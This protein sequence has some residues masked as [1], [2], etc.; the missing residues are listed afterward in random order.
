MVKSRVLAVLYFLF[1]FIGGVI[2]VNIIIDINLVLEAYSSLNPIHTYDYTRL[3]T[4]IGVYSIVIFVILL[5][6]S[7]S[8]YYLENKRNY[9]VI[10]NILYI[11]ATLYVYVTINK[12]FYE[13]QEIDYLQ[14]GEYWITVFMGIFYV[15]GAIL[16]S[17]IGYI[18]IRNY[19]NRTNTLQI[20]SNK[21]F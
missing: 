7:Y 18:T 13:V 14:Q 4:S 21:R 12:N 8:I 16:I 17:S 1:L 6:L 2:I 15:I 9:I 10:S 3:Q 11:G 5:M 19:T 20:K